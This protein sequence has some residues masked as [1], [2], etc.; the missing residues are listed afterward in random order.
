MP[1]APDP[2]HGTCPSLG[3]AG[4]QVARNQLQPRDMSIL[5][6]SRWA[7]RRY[8]QSS[9]QA[10]DIS[11]PNK[12]HVHSNPDRGPRSAGPGTPN[13]GREPRSAQVQGASLQEF[14]GLLRT[15]RGSGLFKVVCSLQQVLSSFGRVPQGGLG[16]AQQQARLAQ[17]LGRRR[18]QIG[19]ICSSS[20]IAAVRFTSQEIPV[21]AVQ[22]HEQVV[23]C[24]AA[25]DIGG[26]FR[27]FNAAQGVRVRNVSGEP[28]GCRSFIELGP[29]IEVPC[30][31]KR[32]GR[33]LVV[34]QALLAP[35]LQRKAT[36][37]ITQ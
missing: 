21:G 17:N 35:R 14:D 18:F 30:R 25:D 15:L 34:L 28:H 2:D 32:R 9:P 4:G 23:V 3:A 26:Q 16:P 13:A 20:S 24:A 8:V 31:R 19:K 22:A 36:F 27:P 29:N 37:P 6:R 11:T 33:E 10:R 7:S 12:G 5:G 1:L